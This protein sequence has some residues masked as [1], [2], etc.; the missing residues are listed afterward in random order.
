MDIRERLKHLRM[1]LL[2]LTQPDFAAKI[3]LKSA[4]IVHMMESG[5]R[6]ITDRTIKSIHDEF[7]VS[8][9][10]LRT[11]E[12][13]VFLPSVVADPEKQYDQHG[14]YRPDPEK[15]LG[16]ERGT[17]QW[18]A[19]E[20]LSKI[21]ASADQQMIGAIF[22]NLKSFSDAADQKRENVELKRKVDELEV[23]LNEVMGQLNQKGIIRLRERR[24]GADR[25]RAS[26]E[27]PTAI[28]RRSGGDRRKDVVNNGATV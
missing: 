27:C 6:Q 4:S 22:S 24:S 3:G 7:H 25:R 17:Q 13:N 5:M 18:K 21:Y 10:W 14:G 20:M 11:G 8:E 23:K 15:A 9:A 28:E 19:F 16:I 26:C 1:K 2:G 12:G